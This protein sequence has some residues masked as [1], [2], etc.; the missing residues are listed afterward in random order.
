MNT[1]VTLTGPSAT[2]KSTLE[3]KLVQEHGFAKLT[4]VTTR[5]KRAGEVDGVDYHFISSEQMAALKSTDQLVEH[6]EFKGNEYGVTVCEVERAFAAGKP[7]AVV[8]EP[9]GAKQISRFAALKGWNHLAVFLNN[10][11]TILV[12]R[13]IERMRYDR[14]VS[15]MDAA[16]RLLHLVHEEIRWAQMPHWHIVFDDFGPHNEAMVIEVLKRR[17]GTAESAFRVA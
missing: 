1:I 13:F 15:S 14:N 8:V 9:I 16:E 2:G 5:P 12:A 3:R 6:V 17:V 4:S 10:P 11:L 7:I